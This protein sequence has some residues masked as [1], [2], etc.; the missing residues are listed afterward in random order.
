MKKTIAVEENLIFCKS[1]IYIHEE[2][3]VL[4]FNSLNDKISKF[5]TDDYL[6]GIAIT[7]KLEDVYNSDIWN[8]IIT[9]EMRNKVNYEEVLYWLTGGDKEWKN[10]K[11]IYNIKWEEAK[12]LFLSKYET[13][14][15]EINENAYKLNDVKNSFIYHFNLLDIY[16]HSLK[17]GIIK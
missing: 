8:L 12:P 5:I 7:M 14:L 11:S 2:D 3:N 13:I 6:T 16:E 10:N 9:N 1:K 15:K 4:Y 17:L